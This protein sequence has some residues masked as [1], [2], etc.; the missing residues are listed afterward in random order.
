MKSRVGIVGGGKIADAYVP[1]IQI[2]H[3]KPSFARQ[4]CKRLL[5]AALPTRA[6]LTHGRRD[7]QQFALT[8]DDGPDPVYTPQILELLASRRVNA[9]FFLQ[10]NRAE[11]HPDLVR[12]IAEEGHEVA[13]HSYSH[14]YFQKIA[15]RAAVH[16]VA[17]TALIL[18]R[19]LR[20]RCRLFRPPF[21]KLCVQSL[22]GCWRANHQMILWSVD[23]KDYRATDK[24]DITQSLL[25][26]PISNGDI[27]L[28]HGTNPSA[29]AALPA[30]IAA[31]TAGGRK[32]VVVSQLAL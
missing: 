17:A 9:T 26:Q 1:Q 2:N 30:V 13:N 27:I 15:M 32:G 20:Q 8:F 31:A 10:G 7:C 4:A 18:N 14:P 5:T 12:R 28:Y 19:L 3:P 6:L 24:S 25:S 22:L 21:G 29:V 23:L 16:E 11:E